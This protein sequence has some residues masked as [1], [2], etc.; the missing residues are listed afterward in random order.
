MTRLLIVPAAGLGTRLGSSLPKALTPVNGRPMIDHVLSHGAGYCDRALIIVHPAAR[1]AM[2]TYSSNA[3]IPVSIVEQTTPTGMLDAIL[4]AIPFV[5]TWPAKRVWI[6]WC[7]QV[8]LS[9]ETARRVAERENA[10][11]GPGAVFPT[12]EQTPPYIHFTRNSDGRVTSVLQRREK[13]VMPDTGES[14]SGFFS[15]SRRAFLEWLPEYARVAPPGAGT[16][17]K[18]F[19]PFLP[20]LAELAPV[21]TVPLADPVEAHGV[22]TPEDLARA[23]AIL[24]ARATE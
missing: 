7:D 19:L 12:V 8:L 21:A 17:E 16:G 9:N 18:N 13:D 23:E 4:L 24:R 3:P 1:S 6:S 20:W 2:E 15:L 11:D 5:A 10:F 14:D 22:N